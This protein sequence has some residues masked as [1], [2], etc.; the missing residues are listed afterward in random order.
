MAEAAGPRPPAAALLS[1]ATLDTIRTARQR[2]PSPRSA[3]LPAL[4]AVQDQLGH[5]PPD[6]MAEVAAA[7][8]IGAAEVEAVSTFYAMYFRRPLGRH[9]V[10]VCTN[11]S[12]ALRGADSVVRHLEGRLG[13]ADGGT[14]AD[15]LVTLESTVECLGACGGAPALQVDRYSVED[16]TPDILDAIVHRLRAGTA[17][18]APGPG[19]GP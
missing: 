18:A 19:A 3:A 12:C 11:V 1:Q 8:G 15:G 6:A 14:S 17:T 9:F 7:L 10:Q 16:C 5:V 13:I 2:Y 4:W